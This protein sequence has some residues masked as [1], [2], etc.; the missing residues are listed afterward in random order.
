LYRRA[1]VV[2]VYEYPRAQMYA[3]RV[4][5]SGEGFASMIPQQVVGGGVYNADRATS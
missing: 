1:S 5:F 4:S 2:S 3:W